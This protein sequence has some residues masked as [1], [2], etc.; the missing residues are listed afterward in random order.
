[1]SSLNIAFSPLLPAAL[2]A[3]LALGALVVVGLSLWAGR[4]G[5]WLRALGLALILFALADPSLVREDRQPLRDVVA[6]V[7]DRSASQT[8]GERGAQTQAAADRTRAALEAM[9]NIEVRMVD[10]GVG[11]G[12]DDGTQLFSSLAAA[13]V[14]V[15]PER[16]GGA[17]LITDGVVH[18]IPAEAAQLG[19]RAPLHAFVTGRAG[20]RDRRIELVEAPRFGA[21]ATIEDHRGR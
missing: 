20:E 1:M 6:V 16:V 10:G 15:P 14:D 4:R 3:A 17:I 19:F 21:K 9:D 7:V 5:T 8:I 2:I 18:D 12:Q 13:L 11:A